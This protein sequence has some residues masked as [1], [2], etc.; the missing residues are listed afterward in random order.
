MRFYSEVT[1]KPLRLYTNQL[2]SC[3]ST[4]DQNPV[5]FLPRRL[6]FA[7]TLCVISLYTHN[8]LRLVK[9]LFSTRLTCFFAWRVCH[10]Q[11]KNID[12]STFHRTSY[13]PE[14]DVGHFFQSQP[15]PK[16]FNSTQPIKSLSKPHPTQPIIA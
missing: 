16:F 7:M 9:Q 1:A 10:Y 11:Y 2:L 5:C 4:N 12:L 6:K 15:N 3:C 14:L 8:G 13:S